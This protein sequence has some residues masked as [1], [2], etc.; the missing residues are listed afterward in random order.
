ML[1]RHT[2]ELEALEDPKNERL[3]TV[4]KDVGLPAVSGSVEM[5]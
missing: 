2:S 1:V 3:V 5:P 4:L